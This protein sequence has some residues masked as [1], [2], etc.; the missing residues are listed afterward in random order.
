M[1]TGSAAMNGCGGNA[2]CAGGWIGTPGC[3]T[4]TCNWIPKPTPR[5]PPRWTAAIAAEQAKTDDD[6]QRSF[7]QLKA[8]AMVGLVTGA[9]TLD[10]RV[11]E[12]TVLIDLDTLRHGLHDHSDL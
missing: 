9:R 2:A 5:C 7:D 10:R 8:D 6:E 11:P 3:A 4:P 1:T 12:V